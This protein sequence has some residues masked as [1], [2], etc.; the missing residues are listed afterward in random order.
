MDV[1]RYVAIDNVCAWPILNRLPDGRIS[2]IIFNQPTHGGWEGEI[3]CWLSGDEGR[4]WTRAGTPVPHE[5]GIARMNHAAG[6]AGNG[7][8]VVIVGG[9][10]GRP[11]K[12]QANLDFSRSRILHP[13]AAR[14]SDG[15]CSWRACQAI[16]PAGTGLDLVPF[17]PIVRRPDG[18]L[19]ASFYDWVPAGSGK[20]AQSNALLYRSG[21][22]GDSWQFHATIA[23][24]DYNE[25]CIHVVDEKRCL[26]AAR[27]FNNQ[28]VHLF[29]SDDGGDH[30]RFHE[31][32]TG[33]YEHNAHL[34]TLPD[35][36]I[37]MTYG[38]RHPHDL[39]LAIRV[40]PD[41]GTT[42][43]R[44]HRLLQ[45]DDVERYDGG[46]PSGVTVGDDRILTAYYTKRSPWHQRYHM[47]TLFWNWKKEL[48]RDF[49]R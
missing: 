4:T 24:G 39:A 20:P 26:A 37:L 35:G 38:I 43:R 32:V 16:P 47:G 46:Y 22:D 11:P 12:G 5:A 3:E 19:L 34:M 1:E 17:G 9:H 13:V 45:I 21:D 6:I 36:R 42:W 48:D 30:W 25:T 18:T 44:P 41:K 10:G 23:A 31:P 28:T 15:G 29:L 7:D 49:D 33:A 8:L 27:T 14:S 2:A 40:S